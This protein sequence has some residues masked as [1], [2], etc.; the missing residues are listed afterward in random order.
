MCSS[1][2]GKVMANIATGGM[3][4]IT[5]AS[6]KLYDKARDYISGEAQKKSA[7]KIINSAIDSIPKPSPTPSPTPQFSPSISDDR[8]NYISKMRRGIL[9]NIKTSASGLTGTGA[10]LQSG[11][12]KKKL[13]E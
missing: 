6:Y 2:I 13:G 11:I 10:N 12:G 9:S 4:G 3:Y 5:E 8:R 7:E 1:D